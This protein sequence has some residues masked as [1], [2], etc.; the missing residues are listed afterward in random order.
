MELK[1]ELQINGGE[2]ENPYDFIY[3]HDDVNL[4]CIIEGCYS[5]YYKNVS[6]F[7]CDYYDDNNTYYN[8]KMHRR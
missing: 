2:W 6:F 4:N 7:S 5:S 8:I 3:S 1:W